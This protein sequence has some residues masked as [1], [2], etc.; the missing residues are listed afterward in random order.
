[1][2]FEKDGFFSPEIEVFRRHVRETAPSKVWFDYALSLNRIGFDMLRRVQTALRD[3]RQIALN[4]HFVR[5]HWSFQSALILAERGLVPD[6]RV[7]L[8]SAVGEGDSD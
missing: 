6:A 3:N 4:A 1:M 5:V 7:V 2:T 8:R